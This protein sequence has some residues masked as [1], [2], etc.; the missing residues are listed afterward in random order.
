MS[1]D[2]ELSSILNRR[3]Q[4]LDALENG[5]VVRQTFKVVNIYSEFPEFSR[6][7]IKDY[8]DAFS[9]YAI[10]DG[11]ISLTELKLLLRKLGYPQRPLFLAG[12]FAEVDGNQDGEISFREF[13]QIFRNVRAKVLVSDGRLDQAHRP[14]EIDVASVGVRG[15]KKFFEARIEQQ[16]RTNKFY[17][18]ILQ[19]REERRRMEEEWQL[20]RKQ[21]RQ[22]AVVLQLPSG[23]MLGDLF[24]PAAESS[25]QSDA[26][27]KRDQDRP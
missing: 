10:G 20:R 14:T 6:K 7:E 18:E 4:I 15:A 11:L 26:A 3:L 17:E 1:A 22:L 16:L 2:A 9:K 8:R 27:E 21:F 24:A 19:E 25:G 13:L 23:R 5:Q 12:M